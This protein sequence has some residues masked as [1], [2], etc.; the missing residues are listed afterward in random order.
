MKTSIVHIS[1]INYLLVTSTHPSMRA[2]EHTTSRT[3]KP[4]H[5]PNTYLTWYNS[6]KSLKEVQLK[7][8]LG[9]VQFEDVL[10]EVLKEVQLKEI[11]NDILE[12]VQVREVLKEVLENVLE[13]VLNEV[14][15]KEVQ[16][17]EVLECVL[18]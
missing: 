4:W 14:Q 5:N 11:L 8:V 15:L 9:E 12:E 7:Y 2:H 1:H 3:A 10:E 18:N 16:L 17:K 6:G 13:E